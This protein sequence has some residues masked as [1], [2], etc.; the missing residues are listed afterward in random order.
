[1]I[2][3][4]TILRKIT[5]SL[6]PA[7]A[8]EIAEILNRV[9]PMYG[10]ND[11]DVFHE[12]W[13]NVLVETS[14]L[15]KLTEDLYYTTPER[16]MAVWP[17]RFPSKESALPY[18]RNPK[19]L[20]NYVYAGRMGNTHPNDGYEMRGGGLLHLTGRGMYTRFMLYFRKIT[21]HTYTVQ[22]IAELVRNDWEVAVH[23]ACWVFAIA[24]GLLDE[25]ISDDMKTIVKR[26][27]GGLTDYQKRMA[28]YEKVKKYVV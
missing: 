17:G 7:K 26:I 27:N 28:N 19:K 9:L 21:G 25:A 15:T 3:T 2:L 11:P 5:P 22:Q 18:L 24:K 10:M 23:S 14:N 13:A 6:A 8:C 4:G 16:L 1:M 12:F 20:A